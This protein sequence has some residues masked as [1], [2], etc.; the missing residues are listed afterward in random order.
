MPHPS[1]ATLAAALVLA[2]VC[3]CTDWR[4]GVIPNRL[5]LPL[6]VMAPL[7]H[8]FSSRGL[9]PPLGGSGAVFAALFSLLSAGVCAIV[10]LLL[11]W[12]RLAG[13]GDVKLFA[14]LGALLLAGTG[15]AAQ[16]FAFATAAFF[17][18]ARLAY[19]GRLFSTLWGTLAAGASLAG[20]AARRRTLPA[21][22]SGPI[23]LGPFIVLGTLVALAFFWVAR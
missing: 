19:H 8:A 14:A 12:L 4:R 7:I 5:T 1:N 3:A 9:R 11:F 22:M 17:V 21:E 2:C 10:P 16:F 13:G 23:R 20:P 6:L 18:P 15:L